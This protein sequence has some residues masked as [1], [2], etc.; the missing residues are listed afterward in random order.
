LFQSE[1]ISKLKRSQQRFVR[2]TSEGYRKTVV[3]IL[4]VDDDRL[5][6]LL[7]G[8]ALEKAG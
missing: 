2:K 7:L 1:G 5:S 4:I 3:K 6:R 8:R